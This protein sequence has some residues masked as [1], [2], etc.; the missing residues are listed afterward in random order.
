VTFQ[1]NLQ[2]NGLIDLAT[3][4]EVRSLQSFF[5]TPGN[6]LFLPG[7]N[8]D[9]VHA[10]VELEDGQSIVLA[11][12]T[13][14]P[15][16]VK[17]R[18]HL[19]NATT[20]SVQ[21][22]ISAPSPGLSRPDKAPDTFTLTTKSGT[23]AELLVGSEQRLAG[24]DGRGAAGTQDVDVGTQLRFLPVVLAGG[25]IFLQIEAANTALNDDLGAPV[26]GRLVAGH[27]AQRALTPLELT[28]G[29]TLAF[30]QDS[31]RGF[32]ALVTPHVVGTGGGGPPMVQLQLNWVHSLPPHT[33]ATPGNGSDTFSLVTL[34]GRPGALLVGGEQAV[35]RGAAGVQF[36]GVG[37]RLNFM[38]IVLANGS[39]HVEIEAE[40][41]ALREVLG[42]PVPGGEVAGHAVERVHTTVQLQ[43]GQSIV[44]AE[45]DL[46]PFSVQVTVHLLDQR[47][48]LLEV[49]AVGRLPKLVPGRPAPANAFSL[50]TESGR[51]GELLV[52][53][54]HAEHRGA[55]GVPF[56]EVGTDLN[57]VPIILRS[58]QVHLVISLQVSFLE[59]GHRHRLR[60]K[61]VD[62]SVDLTDGQSLVI[63]QDASTGFSVTA[64]PHVIDNR[65]VKLDLVVLGPRV[66]K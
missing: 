40:L 25:N 2:D 63:A 49:R 50:V 35:P 15:F 7:L 6:D 41:S 38:P 21:V 59:D 29:H 60:S 23:S 31:A 10:T 33:P 16:T 46:V 1:A 45:D 17:V 22:L 9:R 61:E 57:Y 14:A 11:Q 58:G 13:K 48:V 12:D 4:V 30:A 34:S 36:I 20:V 28:D 44:L 64:T 66:V 52:G 53:G 18:P 27:T 54:E 24:I 5:G 55:A 39:I 42:V 26:G 19:V 37:T 65:V 47:M 56:E 32:L 62:A 43:D 51:P 8:T 3:T